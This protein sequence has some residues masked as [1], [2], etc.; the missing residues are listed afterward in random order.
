MDEA[1]VEVVVVGGHQ[2]AEVDEEVIFYKNYI[3]KL[4][5]IKFLNNLVIIILML[6]INFRTRRGSWSS[7]I[8]SS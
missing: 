1:E 7:Q 4:F 8:G 2:G 6:H 3:Q 5:F